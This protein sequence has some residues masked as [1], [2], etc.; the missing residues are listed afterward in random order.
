MKLPIGAIIMFAVLLILTG[1]PAKTTEG[2]SVLQITD[3]GLGSVYHPGDTA[4]GYLVVYNNGNAII[5]DVRV[6]LTIYPEN[7]LGLP[8]GY[9]KQVYPVELSPGESRRIEYKQLIPSSLIG[10]S[11]LGHYRLEAKIETDNVYV[12]TLQRSVD[13][14]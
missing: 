3:S 12:T 10:F 5:H 7:L 1:D 13:I 9:K 14:V 8:A 4:V 6:T 2:Q 11:T